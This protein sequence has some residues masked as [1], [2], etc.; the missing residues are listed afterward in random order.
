MCG[1][2]LTMTWL[3]TDWLEYHV[4]NINKGTN[5]LVSHFG[6][7]PGYKQDKHSDVCIKGF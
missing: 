2:F 4:Q 3:I 6:Q 7:W 5:A 1:F